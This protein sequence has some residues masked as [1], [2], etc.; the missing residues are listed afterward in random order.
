VNDLAMNLKK[1]KLPIVAGLTSIVAP[2]VTS[3]I[4][5]DILGH[6]TSQGTLMSLAIA[7]GVGYVIDKIWK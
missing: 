1:H 3:G 6:F 7:V 5:G 4:P 2:L